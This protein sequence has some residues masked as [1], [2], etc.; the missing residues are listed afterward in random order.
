MT[1]TGKLVFGFTGL[2]GVAPCVYKDQGWYEGT[3]KEHNVRKVRAVEV[4][5]HLDGERVKQ[6]LC[7]NNTKVYGCRPGGGMRQLY[8][9]I[10]TMEAV[11]AL[12]AL[13][14]AKKAE[15]ELHSR[16]WLRYW[17]RSKTDDSSRRRKKE[18]L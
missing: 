8:P 13:D 11:R 4:F 6:V 18:L 1:M 15:A 5:E 9:M 14:D 2:N 3:I 17:A 7:G 10:N 12:K 16:N